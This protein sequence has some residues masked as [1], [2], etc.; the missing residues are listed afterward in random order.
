LARQS[1]KARNRYGFVFLWLLAA[2]GVLLLLGLSFSFYFYKKYA[3]QIE[4]KLAAGPFVKTARLYANPQTVRVGDPASAENIVAHLRN[5]AYTATRG[6]LKGW[7][8]VRP[9]AIEIYPGPDSFFREDPFVLKISKG[10]VQEIISLR[11]NTQ[12]NQYQ[13]EPVLITNLFDRQRQKRQVMTFDEFPSMLVNAV[14]SVEDKRFFKHV[15]FDPARI[16]KAAYV[17]LKKGHREQGA[18][19]LTMQLA[20]GIWLTP[21]KTFKRKAAETL[22]TMHLE[23]TLT[24][25]QIFEYYANNVDMGR[26]GSYHILGFGEAS[27]AYFGKDVK[28]LTLAE[29]ATLAG[30][31]QRPSFTNP[32]RWPDRAKTRRNIVLSLMRDNGYIDER[33]YALAAAEPMVTAPGAIDSNEAPYFVDLANEWLQDTFQDRD[34]QSENYHVYTTLDP[35]LQKAAMEAVQ[36]GIAEVDALIEKRRQRTK[37][38][39]PEPQVALVALDAQT[40]EVRALVGGRNYGVSQL[41]R[42]LAKRQPGSIFKP[43]VYAAAIDTAVNR[44][45]GTP[46]LTPDSLLDD[47][48]TVFEFDGQTYEPGNHGSK[49]YGT[50]SMRFALAKSLNVPTVKVAEEVGYGH[51]AALAKGAGLSGHVGTPAIALGSYD[52]TP[53]DMAGAYTIFTNKGEYVRPSLVRAVFDSA[54]KPIFQNSIE[55]KPVVDPRVA[56]VLVNM[57]EEVLRSGTG[58]GVRGRGFRLPAAGKTGTSRD[59]WFAGFTTKLICIVWVGFD[60]GADLKLDGAKSALPIWTEF[61][62]RAH[63]VVEYRNPSHFAPPEGVTM[64]SACGTGAMEA[65]ISGTEPASPCG[66]ETHAASWDEP[67]APLSQPSVTAT[68]R[69]RRT[70]PEETSIPI[71]PGDEESEAE[72]KQKKKFWDRIRGIFK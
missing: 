8:H 51:V 61:M 41:N 53:L 14:V 69:A 71:R 59:G 26:R 25:E 9:D 67:D 35:Q 10:R 22:I 44:F 34:F 33:E 30:L 52:A 21:E 56:Y 24:K 36:A 17:D 40:G 39:G 32:V 72:P 70:P 58:A 23:R 63:E 43:F 12:R 62:K 42:V 4:E 66:R 28:R 7:Y 20:R 37:T 55:R 46:V 29:C 38:S 64:V 48:P 57:M 31:I 60:D 5:C 45:D 27:R 18:S 19:T 65:F 47:E 15:G 16:V 68:A 49:F 11:D 6:N 50:V 54:G 13:L 3:R 2:L 1:R